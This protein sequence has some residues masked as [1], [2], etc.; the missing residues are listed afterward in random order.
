MDGEV[1]KGDPLCSADGNKLLMVS[2]LQCT[3]KWKYNA[4][5]MKLT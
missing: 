2:P 4:V 1:G 3:G 5:H